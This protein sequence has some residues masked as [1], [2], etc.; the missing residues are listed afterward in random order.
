MTI[1]CWVDSNSPDMSENT[2]GRKAFLLG[3]GLGTRLRPLTNSLPKPLVPVWNK[4]L[5]TFAMDHLHADLGISDFLI[6]THHC[7]E[8]YEVAFPDKA[9]GPCQLDFRFEETLLDTAGGIDNIRDWL[10]TDESFIVYNGDILTDLP[11]EKAWAA[12][13]ESGALATL[14]LRSEGDELRVGFDPDS[15]NVVD[16]R[17]QLNPDWPH[18]YQFTGIYLVSPE[19]LTYIEPGKI[20]SVV[21]AFLRAIEDGGQIC[22]VVIDEGEWSDLGE[23]E[24]YLQAGELLAGGKFP[25]YELIEPWQR[26]HEHAEI[27]STAVIDEVSSIGCGTSVGAGA[28]ITRS[29]VWCGV[30]F[31]KA[32]LENCVVCTKGQ[33]VSGEV[34]DTDF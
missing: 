4:P 20:E 2:S 26:I 12:H 22:G 9:Y 34:Q 16:L 13:E 27:D 7:P 11:L 33:S 5:L 15:G 3:A 8:A 6:N 31:A 32:T 21:L 19:F 10:P 18:R 24:S 28:K 29:S 14:I 1:P 30:V 25:R 17:G 23:R